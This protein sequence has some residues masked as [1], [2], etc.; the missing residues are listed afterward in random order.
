VAIKKGM[1]PRTYYSLSKPGQQSSPAALNLSQ[2]QKET[3]DKDFILM[4]KEGH[5]VHGLSAISEYAY[6]HN[7]D[8][9][10]VAD[11]F[12]ADRASSAPG[13]DDGDEA[14]VVL[15][16]EKT[17]INPNTVQNYSLAD[18]AHTERYG[19]TALAKRLY[20]AKSSH[21]VVMQTEIFKATE[22]QIHTMI[23]EYQIDAVAFVPSSSAAGR[24]FMKEWKDYLDLPLPHVNLVHPYHHSSL[25]QKSVSMT[26]DKLR[27][28]QDKVAIDDH[29]KFNH[30]L[31][32]DD[33]L[34]TGST[35][36]STASSLL[37]EDRAESVSAFVIIHHQDGTTATGHRA[38]SK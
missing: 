37:S 10:Q 36:Q 5:Q 4:K 21:N 27:N 15:L 1:A 38:T 28:A 31:I 29:R 23:D 3:L 30:V 8:P 20:A 6:E 9:Q 2:E 12:L 25:P 33:T 18:Y 11:D 19:Q 34:V 26:T 35:I 17:T 22:H 14:L 13:I 16:E 7:L 24:V 32:L